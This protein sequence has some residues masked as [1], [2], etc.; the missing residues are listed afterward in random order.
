MN[1]F[2]NLINQKF[3]RLTVIERAENTK[4]GSCQWKCQCECGEIIKVRAS[5]LKGGKSK[6]CGCLSKD[7]S[8]EL[9]STHGLSK[10]PL[11]KTWQA[12]KDRCYNE[13]NQF[14]EKYGEKGII[15]CDEWKNS[16]ETFY[17]DIGEKPS[18]KHSLDRID[19]NK[20]YSKE[21]CRWATIKEQNLNKTNTMK[22]S[23]NGETKTLYEWAKLLNIKPYTLYKRIYNQKWSTE[24]ALTRNIQDGKRIKRGINIKHKANY[25]LRNAVNSG[26]IIKPNKCEV[27]NCNE[28]KVYG[29]HYLGY[30]KENW[31]K[32][33]WL[34]SKHHKGEREIYIEYKG[35][36]KT[37]SDWAKQFKLNKK[38]ILW[39]LNK[40]TNIVDDSIFEP[41]EK[42]KLI[43]Y[44]GET[45]NYS[46]WA[47]KIGI[48]IKSLR[49]RIKKGLPIDEIMKPPR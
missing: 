3:E 7:K 49:K 17:K 13:K 42:G 22:L 45:L 43:T 44:N 12:I 14:Y 40:T 6:S 5:A 30:E 37:I 35:E 21:N 26:K 34:C 29:H 20:G 23:F 48:N 18:N 31:L 2:Q 11:Y 33:Q 15:M 39:R 10:H 47:K 24:E 9:H 1:V 46:Q 8:K 38:T 19:V 36:K 41:V 16:F 32:V 4:Q 27:E 28:T 25:S